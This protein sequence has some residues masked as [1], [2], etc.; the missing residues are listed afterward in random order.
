[1]NDTSSLAYTTEAVVRDF[2]LDGVVY[3]E[4]RT[5][6]RAMPS[7]G[8]DKDGYVSAVLSAM[9]SAQAANPGIHT[10]LLLSVDRRN[11][12]AEAHEV[13]ALAQR[14]RDRGVVG[15]DLC[16]D[17]AKGDVAT[18]TPAFAEA[19]ATDGLGITIHFAEA[20]CSATEQE[21]DTILG[22]E[23][24]RLGHVICVPEAVKRRIEEKGGMGLELCLSCNVHAKMIRGGFEAHHFGEWWGRKGAVVVPCV[25]SPFC[26]VSGWISKIGEVCGMCMA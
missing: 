15:V 10:R 19:R 26:Y 24:Q 22:W 12:A 17:P 9:A 7:A 1:V 21:L 2:A 25:S 13:V 20:E 3:L 23:P 6:P 18:F 8:L 14:F 11:T 16:G 4:L 5:T